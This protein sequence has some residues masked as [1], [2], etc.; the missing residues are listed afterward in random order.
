MQLSRIIKM[1]LLSA[2]FAAVSYIVCKTYF[3]NTTHVAELQSLLFTMYMWIPGICALVYM[4]ND[5]IS[6]KIFHKPSRYV[7]WALLLPLPLCLLEI[8]FQGLFGR[9]SLEGILGVAQQYI[10]GISSPIAKGV[11]TFILLY[12]VAAIASLTINFFCVLGEELFWRGY[13][14]EKC[15]HLGFWKASLWTGVLWGLWH[16]PVIVL[17]GL[18]YPQHRYLGM[19]WMIISCMLMAPLMLY[20][21]IR[22][23]S[24]MAPTIFHGL[25]NA[26]LPI[27][28]IFYPTC[29]ELLRAPMGVAGFIGLALMNSYFL[30]PNV[31][32]SLPV[33]RSVAK[34]F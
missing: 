29:S 19:I 4:K 11:I 32:K 17:F 9:F 1:F 10:G 12:V 31:R 23:E 13:L 14:W 7:W 3:A 27:C 25:I 33:E 34:V 20:F 8:L 26:F 22:D 28:V 16:A 30:L 2:L 15:K 6:V 21:R 18:N 24:L 5:G